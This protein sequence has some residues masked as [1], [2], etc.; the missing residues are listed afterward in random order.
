[1]VSWLQSALW[2]LDIRTSYILVFVSCHIRGAK[3]HLKLK[4]N[5]KKTQFSI[6]H[7]SSEGPVVGIQ[8]H[9]GHWTHLGRAVPTVWTVNQDTDPLLCNSLRA[10]TQHNTNHPNWDVVIFTSALM[11]LQLKF[12]KWTH[13]ID[14]LWLDCIGSVSQ[15]KLSD[16]SLTLTVLLQVCDWLKPLLFKKALITWPSRNTV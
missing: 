14:S 11:H 8:Q 7:E 6:Y 15:M 5:K 2:Q 9:R 16:P 12:G 4:Q 3:T 10:H 13:Y 1:M